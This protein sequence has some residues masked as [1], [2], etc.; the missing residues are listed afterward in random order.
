MEFTPLP[1]RP[2]SLTK[3]DITIHTCTNDH[4]YGHIQIYDGKRWY[5]DF[6]QKNNVNVYKTNPPPVYYYRIQKT[7]VN[8]Y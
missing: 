6:V 7:G 8:G 3:G 5:S 2:I 1:S 4:G